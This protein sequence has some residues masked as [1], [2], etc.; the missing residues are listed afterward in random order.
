MGLSDREKRLV[1]LLKARG[2]IGNRE[3]QA[4]FGVSKPT[5]SRHL[6]ALAKQGVLTR[7]G[8]TGKGTYYM[9]SRKGLTKGSK[10]SRRG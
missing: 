9:L 6:D 1:S 3:Y 7:V 5:A 2:R 8:T 10:G 4:A